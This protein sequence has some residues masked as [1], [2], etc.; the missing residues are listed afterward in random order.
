MS[1]KPPVILALDI[2]KNRSGFAVGCST[3]NAPKWG[4]YE[5]PGPWERHE[6]KR[7]AEWRAFL[8]SLIVQHGVTVLAVERLFIDMKDFDF[9]GTEPMLKF[10]GHAEEIAHAHKLEGYRVA[11]NQWRCHFVGTG[12]APKDIR[13]P[14]ERTVWWKKAALKRCYDRFWM[15]EHHDEAEALGILDFMLCALDH[16][17]AHKWGPDA[18]RKDQKASEARFR[19]E[20]LI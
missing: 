1:E 3:W 7:Q 18:R 17:Y 16:D 14:S 5:L 19:G 13:K 11:I 2:A 12:V 8:E 10:H 20:A 15:C 4:V 9:N 6:G